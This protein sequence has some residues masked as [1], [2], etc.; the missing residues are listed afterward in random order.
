MDAFLKEHMSEKAD[1]ELK[2]RTAMMRAIEAAVKDGVQTEVKS[3]RAEMEALKVAAGVQGQQHV[4]RGRL[5]ACCPMGSVSSGRVRS[6]P[7]HCSAV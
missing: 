2:W 7:K 6:P 1:E 4:R 3:A 5:D